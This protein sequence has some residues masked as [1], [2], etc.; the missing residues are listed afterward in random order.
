MSEHIDREFE[1]RKHLHVKEAEADL[2]SDEN[3][4][5]AE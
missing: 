3:G 4:T 2:I 1:R 5:K